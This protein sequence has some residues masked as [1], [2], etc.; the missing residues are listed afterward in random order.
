MTI[1]EFAAITQRVIARDGF[2]EF[3]PTACYPQRRD[4]RTL[5]GLPAD[6]EPGPAVLKWAMKHAKPD[7][8]LLIAFKSGPSEFTIVRKQGDERE[9]ASFSVG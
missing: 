1:D 5:A 4:I 7:D 2:D 6:V 9:S 3:M 8:E